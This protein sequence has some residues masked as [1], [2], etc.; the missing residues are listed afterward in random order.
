M[1]CRLDLWRQRKKELKLTNRQIAD[2][3]NL[4]L[5]TVEQII[6]GKIKSPRLDTVEAIEQALEINQNN[7][8]QE[9][10]MAGARETIKKSITPLE[11]DMLYAFREV[12]KKL[13]EKGQRAL[14]DVAETMAGIKS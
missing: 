8:T 12:G 5:R 14:I 13:G 4:P 9:E 11:D 7:I 10:Y 1:S 3:A 2:K 6:C